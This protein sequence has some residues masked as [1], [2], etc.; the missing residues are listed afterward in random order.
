MMSM[1]KATGPFS[2]LSGRGIPR[3]RFFDEVEGE[4]AVGVP[5]LKVLQDVSQ[6]IIY[7]FSV[8]TQ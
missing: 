3:G 1:T 6:K 8:S 7:C 2:R 5:A 4:G